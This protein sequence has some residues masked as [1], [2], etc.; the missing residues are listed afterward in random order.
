[1]PLGRWP[2][3][4]ALWIGPVWSAPALDETALTHA[5]DTFRASAV[6][7]APTIGPRDMASL[8]KGKVVKYRIKHEE[9]P[10][11]AGGLL[12]SD[13]SQDALWLG[14]ADPHYFLI[15]GLVERRLRYADDGT[16]TWY[17]Y[18]DLPFPLKDRHWMVDVTI[19]RRLIASTGGQVWERSWRL[20]PSGSQ[21]VRD[22][23]A[24]GEI[25][26]SL[27]AIDDAIYTP[28]A[29]GSWAVIPL[30]DGRNLLAYQAATVVGGH[31]PDSLVLANAL[32]RLDELMES[33]L[34]QASQ[35]MP[36]HYKAGHAPIIGGD[37]E[38]VPYLGG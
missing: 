24:A 8:M 25:P 5:L 23:I 9:G 21:D 14:T 22:Y 2:V 28:V 31:I 4:L 33:V 7:P 6:H 10:Q 3:A 29:D 36:G 37:L 18:L 27:A 38:P 1:M 12:I 19:N 16:A 26:V 13:L 15:R 11:S 35:E 32:L 34:H 30:P 20:R 17:G